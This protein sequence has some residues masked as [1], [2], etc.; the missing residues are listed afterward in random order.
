MNH[1]KTILSLA[2]IAGMILA[3][4]ESRA[5]SLIHHW[6]LDGDATDSGTTGG[7][8]GTEQGG[9]FYTTGGGGKFGE[10]VSLDGDDDS[11]FVNQSSLPATD[12]SLTAWVFR[13]SAGIQMYVAG[14]QESGNV[15]AFLRAGFDTATDDR[16]FV[17][18]LP[19]GD[20]KRV[21]GGAIPLNTWTHLAMT[22]SSTAG[23]EIFVNGS[24]VGTDPAGTGHTTHN[25]FRI[26]AR[27]DVGD[28]FEFDG[29]IDDVA[30]FDSVLDSTQLSNVINSG[31]ANYNI[32]E[33]SSVA[34]FG[35]GAFAL[36]RRRK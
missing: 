21:A 10:A 35:L 22:V 15:G 4:T 24:S 9:A 33:P 30:V 28:T 31:A 7:H 11:I 1:T 26:G 3:A 19:P 36:L 12:F 17:N 8:N 6:A 32:P 27:P 14:T 2:V 34:L 16:A 20:A 25:N 18:L 29:L 5:A 13:E 23:L